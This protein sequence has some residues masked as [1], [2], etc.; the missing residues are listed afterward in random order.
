[1][2]GG[3]GVRIGVRDWGS[4][5]WGLGLGAALLLPPQW[6]RRSDAARGPWRGNCRG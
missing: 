6:P 5:A 1:M 4:S 3:L 2:F